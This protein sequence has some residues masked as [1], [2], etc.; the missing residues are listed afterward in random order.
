MVARGAGADSGGVETVTLN[1]THTVA[2]LY[3]WVAA[4]IAATEAETAQQQQQ[5]QQQQGTI[6][7]IYGVHV[8]F[9]ATSPYLES[10]S[11]LDAIIRWC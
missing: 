5:E 2:D 7:F 11:P 10:S 4:T 8:S 1:T 9:G 3:A 6:E